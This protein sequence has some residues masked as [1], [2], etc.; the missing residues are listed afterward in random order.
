MV[1]WSVPLISALCF[2]RK[3]HYDEENKDKIFNKYFKFI[4]CNEF[5]S[6]IQE[7]YLI[8]PLNRFTRSKKRKLIDEINLS[9]EL[10]FDI[11]DVSAKIMKI[12]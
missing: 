6:M 8:N 10:N 1:G 5:N 4:F 11:K 2:Y 12:I 3:G 9:Y 7:F